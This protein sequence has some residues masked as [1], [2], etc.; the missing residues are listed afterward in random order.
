[1]ADGVLHQKEQDL[2]RMTTHI[3]NID[4]VIIENLKS[5]F[6]DSKVNPYAVLVVTDSMD[7]E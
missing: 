2:L 6:V 1:M 5:Q 3:L 4:P 7:F